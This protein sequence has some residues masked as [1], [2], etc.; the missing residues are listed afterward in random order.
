MAFQTTNFLSPSMGTTATVK[1]EEKMKVKLC[2]NVGRRK[3]RRKETET[4]MLDIV[5]ET[6]KQQILS[7]RKKWKRFI[8]VF[9]FFIYIDL[10]SRSRGNR[11]TH[12]EDWHENL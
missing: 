3:R 11:L 12:Q 9:F 4:S 8:L 10:S 5:S 2:Y 6:Q 7:N 1:R